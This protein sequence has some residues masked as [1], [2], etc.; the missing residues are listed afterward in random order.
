VLGNVFGRPA[1]IVDT[2]V[3]R[4]A[5]RLGLSSESDPD[6]IET[7]LQALL[8]PKEWTPFSHRVGFHGRQ[9]CFARKP[10]HDKCAVVQWCPSVD[11]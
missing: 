10:A 5:G 9:V 7:D 4:L 6:K 11:L 8:P 1:I 3:K 2:H